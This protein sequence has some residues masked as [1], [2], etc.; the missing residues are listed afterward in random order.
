MR[1]DNSDSAREEFQIH[2]FACD[3]VLGVG[4]MGGGEREPQKL[5]RYF[6]LKYIYGKL[7]I[8]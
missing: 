7:D 3:F 8:G 2:R 5:Q 6:A 1:K 4:G